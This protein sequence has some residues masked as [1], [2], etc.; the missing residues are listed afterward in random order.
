MASGIVVLLPSS[1]PISPLRTLSVI[2][3]DSI[4]SSVELAGS[5]RRV[6]SQ[7][8]PSPKLRDR[9]PDTRNQTE[10]VGIGSGQSST[11]IPAPRQGEPD[12]RWVPVPRAS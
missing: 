2:D 4:L 3:D 11:F 7:M 5:S 9:K 1:L 6:E 8:W 10:Q 12:L